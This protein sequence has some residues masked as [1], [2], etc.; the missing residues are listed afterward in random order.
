MAIATFY[1]G[2]DISRSIKKKDALGIYRNLDNFAEII[3]YVA[4]GLKQIKFSKTVKSGYIQLVRISETEYRF[5]LTSDNTQYLGAGNIICGIDF[6]ATSSDA[7]DGR[8]NAKCETIIF[9]L[10]KSVTESER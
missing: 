9:K 7:R 2:S 8:L 4:N 3:V 5:D 6:I 10:K 1:T